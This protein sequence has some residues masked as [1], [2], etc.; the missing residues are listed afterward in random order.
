M[1][2]SN[3]MLC[4]FGQELHDQRMQFNLAF[5]EM[6]KLMSEASHSVKSCLP[7]R[8]LFLQD[9]SG[10]EKMLVLIN[11]VLFSA[12]LSSVNKNVD[13]GVQTAIY[14][15]IFAIAYFVATTT[16]LTGANSLKRE[17]SFRTAAAAAASVSSENV[18]LLGTS[19]SSELLT[20]TITP[21]GQQK[22]NNSKSN[23]PI[24][25]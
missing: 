10:L 25:K 8:E 6:Y 20:D 18:V 4:H 21:I 11:L 12:S 13:E 5:S 19:S 9:Y 7:F 24:G 16:C 15:I 23:K 1:D 2:I 14:Y 22:S 3:L 17:A